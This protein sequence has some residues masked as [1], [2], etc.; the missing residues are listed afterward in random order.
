MTHHFLPIHLTLKHVADLYIYLLLYD[1]DATEDG[2]WKSQKVNCDGYFC[3]SFEIWWQFCSKKI[4]YGY[5]CTFVTITWAF[6]HFNPTLNNFFILNFV[7]PVFDVIIVIYAG[8]LSCSSSTSVWS[9]IGS[10]EIWL[11]KMYFIL[12][13]R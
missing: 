5:F 4:L 12:E 3:S 13:F 2:E 10:C 9:P 6:S 7:F 1:D 8:I 11:A